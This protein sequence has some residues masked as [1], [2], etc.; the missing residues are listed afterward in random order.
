MM[1][2]YALKLIHIHVIW[3]SHGSED[4]DDSFLGSKA[5]WTFR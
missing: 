5:T 1:H 3:G 4:V 2:F